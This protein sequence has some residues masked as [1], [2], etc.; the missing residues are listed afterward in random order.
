MISGPRRARPAAIYV[1]ATREQCEYFAIRLNQLDDHPRIVVFGSATDLVQ[2]QSPPSLSGN[3]LCVTPAALLGCIN[4]GQV[5]LSHTTIIAFG[6]ANTMISDR[7]CDQMTQLQDLFRK[8]KQARQAQ[9]LIAPRF[10]QEQLSKLD[11]HS[12]RLFCHV[13]CVVDLDSIRLTSIDTGPPMRSSLALSYVVTDAD[14]TSKLAE[15][16]HFVAKSF[17]Q[18]RSMIIFTQ[19]PDD[20]GFLEVCL[21]FNP[22]VK[23]CHIEQGLSHDLPG[24]TLESVADGTLNTLLMRMDA[25]NS[26]ILAPSAQGIDLAVNVCLFRLYKE[27]GTFS[28]FQKY[29]NLLSRLSFI[30]PVKEVFTVIDREEYRVGHTNKIRRWLEVSWTAVPEDRE[31]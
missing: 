13:P 4:S 30:E 25:A 12:H 18:K 19:L 9:L 17:A 7:N 26:D 15:L 8:Q 21:K 3:I 2:S 24:N 23:L 6:G 20:I 16:Q 27:H 10:S 28:W 29:T 31:S 14:I 5:C 22:E 11:R 1:A